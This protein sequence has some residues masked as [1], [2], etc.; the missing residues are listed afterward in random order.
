MVGWTVARPRRSYPDRLG[1]VN[2]NSYRGVRYSR[3]DVL[4]VLQSRTGRFRHVADL[5]AA[6]GTYN[7]GSLV[8][9]SYSTTNYG[10]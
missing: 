5:Q 9:R 4:L 6:A 7:T 8:G 3:N 1:G 10:R 2:K